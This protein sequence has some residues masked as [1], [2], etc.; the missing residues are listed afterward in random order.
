M[1]A[2][3]AKPMNGTPSKVAIPFP[4]ETEFKRK[5]AIA[6]NMFMLGYAWQKGRI[7]LSAAAIERAIEINGVAVESNL[8]AFDWGRRTA[9]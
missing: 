6:T 7:P 3:C 2:P 9:A 8:S 5:R 1:P 4:L